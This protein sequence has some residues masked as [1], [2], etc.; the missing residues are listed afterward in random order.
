MQLIECV[1]RTQAGA[2][3]SKVSNEQLSEARSENLI[4][5]YY[6]IECLGGEALHG[7]RP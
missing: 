3:T 1:S 5:L 2:D 6:R 4:P 7:F